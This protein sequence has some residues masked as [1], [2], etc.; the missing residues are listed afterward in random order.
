VLPLAL[1]H[2]HADDWAEIAAAFECND[3][4]G[5]GILQAE[6]FRR[7]FSRIANLMP[8]ARITG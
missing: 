4:P 1:R 6:E 8:V 3:D 2:F 5:F 7:L